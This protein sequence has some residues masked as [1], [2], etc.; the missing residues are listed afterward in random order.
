MAEG[1]RLNVGKNSNVWDVKCKVRK[2]FTLTG[3]ECLGISGQTSKSNVLHIPSFTSNVECNARNS[4]C[5]DV[6]DVD[7]VDVQANKKSGFDINNRH[8]VWKMMIAAEKKKIT[9]AYN[10]DGHDEEQQ[11]TVKE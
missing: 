7:D 3:V 11:R 10:R 8:T 6:I 5:T 1:S 9:D 2:G 4:R